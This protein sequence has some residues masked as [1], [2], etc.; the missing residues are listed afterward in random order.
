MKGS[1]KNPR[2]AVHACT[3]AFNGTNGIRL[4]PCVYAQYFQQVSMWVTWQAS[5]C[6]VFLVP[7]PCSIS[8]HNNRVSKTGLLEK[9]YIRLI[10]N[11]INVDQL[12]VTCV[13]SWI[14]KRTDLDCSLYICSCSF[15]VIHFLAN[16]WFSIS[17]L[18][19]FLVLSNCWVDER[20]LSCFWAEW[21]WSDHAGKTAANR[22]LPRGGNTDGELGIPT[23][24]QQRRIRAV[25][26]ACG[27]PQ[28]VWSC[29]VT[30]TARPL[31]FQGPATRPCGCVPACL[32]GH[33]RRWSREAPPPR[34][35]IRQW[36]RMTAPYS[37]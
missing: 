25:Y 4:Y 37:F 19:T 10:H 2:L 16:R 12:H 17:C 29:D 36:S 8:V 22:C 24:E 28:S 34:A 21:Y 13:F 18:L 1:K 35:L 14:S 5:V 7:P 11:F 31:H 20:P 23:P 26:P 9:N 30:A 33:E 6:C 27:R 15:H 32:P 3:H